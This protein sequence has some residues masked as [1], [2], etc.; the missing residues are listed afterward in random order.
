MDVEREKAVLML[1]GTQMGVEDE[2]SL[3]VEECFVLLLSDAICQIQLGYIALIPGGYC[4]LDANTI[5]PPK[6]YAAVQ[7]FPPV[8]LR[9]KIYGWSLRLKTQASTVRLVMT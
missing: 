8:V 9:F 5:Q 6:Y 1:Y 3:W 4:S 7:T 2:A